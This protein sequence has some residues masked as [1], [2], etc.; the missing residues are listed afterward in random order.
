MWI[1]DPDKHTATV[2]RSLEDSVTL[3]E[4]GSLDGGDVLPGF[5]LPLR[6]LFAKLEKSTARPSRRK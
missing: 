2:Y 5:T 6:K 1:I 3:T 4:A